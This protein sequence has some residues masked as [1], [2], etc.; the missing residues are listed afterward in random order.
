MEFYHKRFHMSTGRL[1]VN[2]DRKSMQRLDSDEFHCYK[3]RKCQHDL[4][5]SL[6]N[7]SRTADKLFVEK[8][9]IV[10]VENKRRDRTSACH[11]GRCCGQN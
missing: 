8:S 2:I 6:R 10:T 7:H 3:R 11:I 9:E 4:M 1:S 5:L